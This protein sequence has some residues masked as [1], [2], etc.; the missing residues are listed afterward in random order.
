MSDGH[1]QVNRAGFLRDYTKWVNDAQMRRMRLVEPTEEAKEIVS[2]GSLSYEQRIRVTTKMDWIGPFYCTQGAVLC[3]SDPPQGWRLVKR[4][5][6]YMY[7]DH[8]IS[9]RARDF[10]EVPEGEEKDS[11]ALASSLTDPAAMGLAMS[12]PDAVW[13]LDAMERGLTDG[14]VDWW[15]CD[16]FA[17][18]LVRLYRK[19]KRQDDIENI[20]PD[21]T[22]WVHPFNDLI[23]HWD[24][25]EKLAQS[26]REMCDYHLYWNYDE[27]EEHD[28]E[29]SAPFAM[30][31]PIEIHALEAVRSELSL[32]TPRVEH[33]LLQPPFYPI[34]DFAK[35]IPT[36]EILA[37]DDLLRRII[38]LNQRWCDGLEE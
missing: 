27:T 20:P 23:D 15:D 2:G 28:S 18:Y 31:N 33:E 36:E 14:S 37:E 30:V 26:I 12:R 29:F 9:A 6:L 25:E 8:R 11:F 21:A 4:G 16:F 1:I 32:S 34:P 19:L 10:W 3:F 35:N 38:E 7:W 24:D 22:D 17:A 5:L 13:I